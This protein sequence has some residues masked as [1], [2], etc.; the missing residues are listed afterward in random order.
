MGVLYRSY[1]RLHILRSKAL[2][3]KLFYLLQPEA[4]MPAM[5]LQT[6]VLSFA[7]ALAVL[8]SCCVDA[9]GCAGTC[10]PPDPRPGPPTNSELNAVHS[11]RCQLGCV[12]EVRGYSSLC[13]ST[14]T[15]ESDFSIYVHNIWSL[16]AHQYC[17]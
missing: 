5:Q 12:E 11:I 4:N 9:Q 10:Y 1:I 17:Y 8:Q 15:H 6:R 16:H 13:L 3:S 7:L 14:S 2:R